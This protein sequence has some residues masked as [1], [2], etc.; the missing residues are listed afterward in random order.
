MGV[1]VY[2]VT[3]KKMKLTSGETVAIA[4]YGYRPC[5]SFADEKDK[6]RERMV[7]LNSERSANTHNSNGVD[8]TVF[9]IDGTPKEGSRVY[10]GR[11]I[12]SSYDTPDHPGECIG[13]LVREGK[14]WTTMPHEEW[15][16]IDRNAE[17]A[18]GRC[19]PLSGDFDEVKDRQVARQAVIDAG[20]ERLLK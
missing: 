12:G 11:L 4:K 18:M 1:D 6:R 16:E 7:D 10:K 8:L 20:Y 13:A 9:T 3:S 15:D 14:G 5:S 2:V 17:I 19:T